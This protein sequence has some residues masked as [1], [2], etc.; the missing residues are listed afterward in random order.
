M[1]AIVLNGFGGFES[2]VI[3][4]LPDPKP[5]AG[6]V[7]IAVKAFGV[8]QA[9]THMRK[10]EWAEAAQVSGL[11][12]LAC[13]WPVESTSACLQALY[14]VLQSFLYPKFLYRRS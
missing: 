3:K 7:L 9:E 11:Q 8:N 12:S 4:E 6:R 13:K 1:R 2:L 14:L 10:G 5:I